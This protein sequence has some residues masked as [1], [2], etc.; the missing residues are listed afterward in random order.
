MSCLVVSLMP[1]VGVT[2]YAVTLPKTMNAAL[3]LGAGVVMP[4]VSDGWQSRPRVTTRPNALVKKHLPFPAT[5]LAVIWQG[6]AAPPQI[7]TSPNGKSWTAWRQTENSIDLFDSKTDTH[8]SELIKGAKAKWVE[9]RSAQRSDF[10]SMKLTVINTTDGPSKTVWLTRNAYGATGQPTIIPRAAWGAD[11]SKRRGSA[12]FTR[13]RKI[14]IHHTNT[15]NNDGDPAATIRAIFSYHVQSRGF[16]DIAYN[17]LIDRAG[18]TYEGRYSRPHTNGESPTG[19]NAN[20]MAVVGAHTSEHNQGSVGIAVMGNTSAL[21]PTP[22]SRESLVNL[23]A[24]EADRHGIDPESRNS[25]INPVS[26]KRETFANV[27]GHNQSPAAN[28]GCPGTGLSAALPS[29]R[30][31]TE[32]AIHS[33]S[34][35]SAPSMP[36]G[37]TLIPASPATD[38]TPNVVGDV[39]R[40]VVRVEV[41]FQGGALLGARSIS[42]VP[43]RGSFALTDSDFGPL[44]LPPE[45]YSVR[46]VAH[47]ALGRASVP[48][49][50]ADGYVIQPT[51]PPLLPGGLDA[52]VP[53]VLGGGGGSNGLIDALSGVLNTLGL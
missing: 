9:L 32:R 14:F 4:T 47:D 31:R 7:R 26:G 20:G 17:F 30:S 48:A 50:A 25:Y 19:E 29:I 34:G 16:Q 1:L 33:Q 44:T 49:P 21:A 35:L 41:I 36:T 37:S 13:V 24:W 27:A 15:P 52:I 43:K 42:V 18:N 51:I 10:A 39:S 22:Q 23:V 6:K 8:Y 2:S 11:E 28:T 53:P 40:S 3:G 38:S 12:E 46:V 5:E 45:T